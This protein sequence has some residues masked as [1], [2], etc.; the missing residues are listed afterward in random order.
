M[1]IK[2]KEIN[3][4]LDLRGGMSVMLEVKGYDLVNALSGY[5]KDPLFAQAMNQAQAN[6]AN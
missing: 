1:V 2:E 3:L 4:G 6:M 5:N